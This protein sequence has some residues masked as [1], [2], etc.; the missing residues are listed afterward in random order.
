[1]PNLDLTPI[2]ARLE[3]ASKELIHI[4][5]DPAKNFVMCVPVRDWDSDRVLSASLDDIDAL[6]E[7]VERL[8]ECLT[9]LLAIYDRLHSRRLIVGGVTFDE[10]GHVVDARRRLEGGG[11]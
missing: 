2:K 1:M 7:E 10:L 6:V 5:K 11:A 3:V 8:R 9:N 4:C